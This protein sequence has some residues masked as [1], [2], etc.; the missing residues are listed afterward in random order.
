MV[1]IASRDW[2]LALLVYHFP[3]YPHQI[4]AKSE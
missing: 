2:F 4:V 3:V 1:H